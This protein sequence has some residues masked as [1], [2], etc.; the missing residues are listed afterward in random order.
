MVDPTVRLLP[1]GGP[2]VVG[3]WVVWLLPGGGPYGA[4]FPTLGGGTAPTL[5]S[6]QGTL[7]VYWCGIK[8]LLG[9]VVLKNLG[10]NI[11]A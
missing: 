4:L 7:Q 1:G 6:S 10:C 9:R 8:S 11:N 3:P 5:G 2:W